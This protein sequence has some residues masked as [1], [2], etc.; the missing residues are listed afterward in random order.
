MR[1]LDNG[2]FIEKNGNLDEA[3]SFDIDLKKRDD[4]TCKWCSAK[5]KVYCDY[6][7]SN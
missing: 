4:L 1:H 5:T 2:T 6:F 3:K 7:R